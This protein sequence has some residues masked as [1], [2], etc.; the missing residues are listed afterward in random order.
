MVEA[1]TAGCDDTRLTVTP[2]AGAG[3]LKPSVTLTGVPPTTG[4]GPKVS[5]RICGAV[6]AGSTVSSVDTDLPLYD[7]VTVT[8]VDAVTIEVVTVLVAETVPAGISNDVDGN[9][10]FEPVTC[11]VAPPEG[12]TSVRLAVTFTLVPPS[13]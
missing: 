12:A 1:N 11:T 3:P 10:G 5:D 6:A 9:A 13:T 2:P 4:F 8:G 7:A